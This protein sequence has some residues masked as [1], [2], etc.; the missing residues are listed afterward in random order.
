VSDNI[1]DA[2]LEALTDAISYKLMLS[3]ATAK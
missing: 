2:S 1:V 3:R